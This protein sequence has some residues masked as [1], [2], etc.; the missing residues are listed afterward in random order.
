MA[1]HIVVEGWE[2]PCCGWRVG[3]VPMLTIAFDPDCPGCGAKKYSEYRIITHA[4]ECY[5]GK[6]CN[7][8]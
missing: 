5:G 2:C 8:G 7:H 6:E 4:E 1:T 3:D